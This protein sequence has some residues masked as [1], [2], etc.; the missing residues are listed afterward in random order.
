MINSKPESVSSKSRKHE[1]FK[2]AYL[3]VGGLNGF[4]LRKE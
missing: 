2:P 1:I 4:L 3:K